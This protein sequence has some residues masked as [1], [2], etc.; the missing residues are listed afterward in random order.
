MKMQD[1]QSYY[2]L[3]NPRTSL[4]VR[5]MSQS[6]KCKNEQR[7]ITLK[8]SKVGLSFFLLHIYLMRSIYIQSFMFIP[9]LVSDLCPVKCS[10]CKK[11]QRQELQNLSE[12]LINYLQS[13]MLISLILQE[14]C[15]GQDFF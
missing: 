11:E 2:F 6:S 8:S 5:V 10:K 9:L 3:N 1:S 14:L 12:I 4:S 7:A 13:L 15:H